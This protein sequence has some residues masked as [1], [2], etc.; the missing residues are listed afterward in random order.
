MGVGLRGIGGTSVSGHEGNPSPCTFAFKLCQA[1]FAISR[2]ERQPSDRFSV[3][4]MILIYE[5]QPIPIP[6]KSGRKEY[7]GA[8]ICN[9]CSHARVTYIYIYIH[10]CS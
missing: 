9:F 5:A 1:Y 7:N 8:L 10:V 2:G 4:K 3:G 6:V